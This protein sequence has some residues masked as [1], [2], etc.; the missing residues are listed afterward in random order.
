MTCDGCIT[1]RYL[2]KLCCQRTA[3]TNCHYEAMRVGHGKVY[4]SVQVSR[5]QGRSWQ[6][7]LVVK[8]C[9]M[10]GY[11]S[12]ISIQLLQIATHLS[13]LSHLLHIILNLPLLSHI[14][15]LHVFS[16]LFTFSVAAA[17]HTAAADLSGSHCTHFPAGAPD[18]VPSP[19]AHCH[20]AHFRLGCWSRRRMG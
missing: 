9:H 4:H 2:E 5:L 8:Q 19:A 15:C 20:L 3:F 13:H 11:P 6:A 14:P 12:P 10:A 18:L 16:K 7:N 17:D 1:V